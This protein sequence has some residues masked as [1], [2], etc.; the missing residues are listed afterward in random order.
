MG[1]TRVY[2]SGSH[3]FTEGDTAGLYTGASTGYTFTNWT[4]SNGNVV[5]TSTD[6]QF[7]V[8][9][10]DTYTA[11]FTSTGSE[12]TYTVTFTGQGSGYPSNLSYG[13]TS[14][15]SHRFTLPSS[16]PTYAGHTFDGWY[17][18]VEGE[19]YDPGTWIDVTSSRPN[20][21]LTATW[22]TNSY[23]VHVVAGTGGS[24]SRDYF[25]GVSHGATISISSNTMTLNNQTSTATPN[26]GY[27][28]SSWSVSDGTAVTS[29]LT[30][31]ASFVQVY[32]MTVQYGTGGSA[33]GYLMAGSTRVYFSG[34][35]TIPAGST[36]GGYAAASSGYEF[37]NWTDGN[38]NVLSTNRD[39]SFTL[40]G[41]ITIKANFVESLNYT[42]TVTFTGQ[43]SGYPSNL[44]YGPTSD[45]SH[46]F[47]LPSSY[48]TYAGH[49]FDGWYDSVEGEYYD[50]GTWID[51]TSSRPNVTLTAT[52]ETNSFII[53]F[54]AGSGGSV[55]RNYIY[56]VAYGSTVS[57]SGNTLT[58]NNLTVTAT[59]DTGYEF[60]SW[61]VSD[62]TVITGARTIT[63]SFSV[64]YY[65]ITIKAGSNGT[66]NNTSQV[67]YSVPYGST[68]TTSKISN[69]S[70][71]LTIKDDGTTLATVT[72]RA[73][74]NYAFNSWSNAGT[75]ITGAKTIT[76]NFVRAYTV[77]FSAGTGGIVIPT[78]IASVPTGSAITVNGNQI[79]IAG[80]IV[81]ARADTGYSF[82]SWSNASGTITST[83]TITA[84]FEVN[85]YTIAFN[86]GTGGRASVDSVSVPYDSTVSTDGDVIAFSTS[87]L[88]RFVTA[89]ADNGY[90]FTSWDNVPS[91][92]TGDTTIGL[93]FTHIKLYMASSDTSKGGAVA[94]RQTTDGIWVALANGYE[95]TPG[96]T[97]KATATAFT[98]YVFDYWTDSTDPDFRSYDSEIYFTMPNSDYTLTAHFRNPMLT[99]GPS[100]EDAGTLTVVIGG[101]T[102][103]SPVE[104]AYNTT[105]QFGAT[106]NAG[107]TLRD[108]TDGSGT[109]L[110]E[111]TPW[112]MR[113]TSGDITVTANFVQT[114]LTF[115]A[116]EGGIVYGYDLRTM[117]QITSPYNATGGYSY[118]VTATA[119]LPGL[120]FDYWEA[121]G[122]SVS[123]D[124]RYTFN[125]PYNNYTLIARYVSTILN[126]Q[127]TDDEMGFTNQW[128]VVNGGQ[129]FF[130]PPT[131]AYYNDDYGVIAYT[132]SGY[133]FA[134]WTDGEGNVLSTDRE[135]T[136]TMPK[137]DLTITANFTLDYGETHWNN[138]EYNGSV[139][140]L[141]HMEGNSKAYDIFGWGELYSYDESS[142]TK[143]DLNGYTIRYQVHAYNGNTTVTAWL[144]EGDSIV[145][146]ATKSLGNWLNLIVTI[147]AKEHKVSYTL[148]NQ[149]I[150]MHNYG[151][152][153]TYD[154]L[155]WSDVLAYDTMTVYELS[156]NSGRYAPYQQVIATKVFL[157]TY[158][159]VMI[160]PT[161]DIDVYWPNMTNIRMN[162][163]SFALYGSE[164]TFNGHSFT[165]EDSK[166]QVQ[167]VTVQDRNELYLRTYEDDDGKHIVTVNGDYISNRIHPYNVVERGITLTNLYL[168]WQDG[169][170]YMTF[171]ND[172]DFTIDLGP[173]SNRQI[174]MTGIW[175]FQSGV[176]ESYQ[177]TVKEIQKDWNT[178]KF[179]FT[180][181]IILVLGLLVLAGIFLRMRSDAKVG[182]YLII[183][184][185]IAIAIIVLGSLAT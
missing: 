13:P 85:Y 18:S 110:S 137:H 41:D 122:E 76:A 84:N 155:D 162:F 99:F 125:M 140:I 27:A 35:S 126:V 23:T 167:Y 80:T 28:F 69:T 66:V 164:A 127:S 136:F 45:T 161:F 103:T 131:D 87:G 141:H 88:P 157:N 50:P 175:Y 1:S 115:S 123:T 82:S 91:H 12:Y 57:I 86:A 73:N 109:V 179:D 81:T 176:Y 153:G 6:Y 9:K 163:F 21:T 47:T 25:F 68:I 98:N 93:T 183:L 43:G 5:S 71:Q 185:A 49:T 119:I 107:Y 181:F 145:K 144:L 116:D 30:V 165:V 36:V 20:V 154:L 53:E 108:W 171:L 39:Y 159:V 34:S 24:V 139:S 42:Y 177:T 105:I 89:I 46:R 72:A 173:Y 96:V 16:Y 120:A 78:E 26:S 11:H 79:T 63:A 142:D 174:S 117:T 44:S 134:S 75:P 92:I 118:T 170:C 65:T 146:T 8:T 59:P 147:D 74:N 97:Y 37:Q 135:Y 160:D 166:I 101:T 121:D 60:S 130:Q 158:G 3:T 178:L 55:S 2:F 4:D 54:Q 168:T 106:A 151:T 64:Q 94:Y 129:A 148:A 51:V 29:N 169:N 32:T 133:V 70:N 38:G 111:R 48:P 104:V 132:Y 62:G 149:Y 22:E 19:Y 14:D 77:S 138:G 114:I 31:T 172:N 61:S 152:R 180:F 7:T 58:L 95:A 128:H 56:N 112:S 100:I 113:M 90:K 124:A 156:F 40:T 15:T 184:G 10:S 33:T 83:R 17:D 52:W 143:F 182:D 150:S 67:S 102:V